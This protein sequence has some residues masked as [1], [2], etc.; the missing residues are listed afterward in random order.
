MTPNAAYTALFTATTPI[1][2]TAVP[3]RS[4]TPG[5]ASRLIIGGNTPVPTAIVRAA[6]NRAPTTAPMIS[7]RIRIQ[8]PRRRASAHLQLPAHD[9]MRAKRARA[10]RELLRALAAA[11]YVDQQA[12]RYPELEDLAHPPTVSLAAR[13]PHGISSPAESVAMVFVVHQ[14]IETVLRERD[15]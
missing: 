14:R 5:I 1:H 10:Q 13:Q 2:P 4:T 6:P 7:A 8:D 9:R 3:H 15:R 12:L 11:T